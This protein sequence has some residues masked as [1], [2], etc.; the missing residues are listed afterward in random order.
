MYHKQLVE[1]IINKKAQWVSHE[2]IRKELLK[3]GWS[4][5]DIDLA[6]TYANSPEKLKKFS[7]G[8]MLRS[9]VKAIY[10]ILAI[11]IA[12][13]LAYIPFFQTKE[14]V[15]SYVIGSITLPDTNKPVFTYGAQ[16]AMSQPDFF[17]TVINL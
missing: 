2:D 8:R 6:F 11:C 10:F 1:H 13:A 12:I 16:P 4:K 9:E 14:E 5:E 7:L 17:N 3:D 15:A